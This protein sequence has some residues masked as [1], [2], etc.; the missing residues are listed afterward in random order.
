MIDANYHNCVSTS[1]KN[2]HLYRVN[3]Y[4]YIFNVCIFSIF[5]IIFGGVLYYK[6][7]NKLTDYEKQQI[8]ER[9]QKYILDKIKYC[10]H[11][12]NIQKQ[13]TMSY[14]TDLPLLP[15]NKW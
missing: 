8:M 5:A 11:N 10:Q 1:L 14:I 6:Y 3:V 13:T 7:T 15:S 9:D 4:Y 12:N 2:C